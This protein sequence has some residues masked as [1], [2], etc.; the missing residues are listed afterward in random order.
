MVYKSGHEALSLKPFLFTFRKNTPRPSSNL[1]KNQALASECTRPQVAKVHQL[2]SIPALTDNMSINTPR[3]ADNKERAVQG[4]DDDI[5][6]CLGPHAQ[7]PFTP[8]KGNREESCYSIQVQSVPFRPFVE[9]PPGKLPFTRHGL[10]E[11]I[12]T[13]LPSES[14]Q[15]FWSVFWGPSHGSSN[16]YFY[17]NDDFRGVVLFNTIEFMIRPLD[18]LQL[19]TSKIPP[20]VL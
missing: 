5:Y 11:F 10:R 16:D 7:A 18:N 1:G 14:C 9:R 17:K 8:H 6:S 4:S 13:G 2:A 12:N 15:G 3:F 19:D 20:R